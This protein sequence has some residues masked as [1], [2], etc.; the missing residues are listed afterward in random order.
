MNALVQW[1]QD[2]VGLPPEIQGRIVQ[3]VVV[4]LLVWLVRRL[5]MAALRRRTT[6]ITHL[7]RWRKGSL[8]VAVMLAFVVIAGLWLPA[9]RDVT[10]FF[11]IVSA[12]LAIALKDIVVNLAGFGFIVWRRPFQVGDRIEIGSHAGDVIDLRVFQFTILEIGNWV[13]AD[14]STGRIMHIPNGMVLATPLANY[15]RGFRYIWNEMPVLV[16]FESNWRKAKD[17]VLAVAVKHGEHLSADAEKQV[18]GAAE[19]F[20]IFYRNLKPAVYT[21]VV[22]SGV[23]LTVRYLCDPKT[24]RGSAQAIWEDILDEFGVCD[25]IDFAYPTRRFYDNVT[26][27]KAGARAQAPTGAG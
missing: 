12:G 26:E 25:D 22:D 5:V 20:M 14:Q 6:D 17:L 18:R 19:K 16:T 13:D 9:V 1:L 15:T 8:R 10:T 2:Y 24:R 23:L 4:I 7:Y 21:S 11:G 3:T 27:G